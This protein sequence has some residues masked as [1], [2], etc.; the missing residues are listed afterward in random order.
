MHMSRKNGH[1]SWAFLKRFNV[2]QMDRD[3]PWAPIHRMKAKAKGVLKP[4]TRRYKHSKQQWERKLSSLIG[5]SLTIDL[6]HFRPLRLRREED[7][8]DWLIWLLETSTTGVLAK[9]LFGSCM[10][11]NAAALKLPR[12]K[13]ED[14]TNDQSRRV[15]ILL[16]WKQQAVDVEVKI[17]DMHLEKTGETAEKVERKYREYSWHHFILLSDDLLTV[18]NSIGSD[19]A[20]RITIHEI[21]WRD[22]VRALRRCLWQERE[23]MLWR[24]WAW[25]FCRAIENKVMRLA[26]PELFRSDIGK[27]QMTLSWLAIIEQ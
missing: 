26:D 2:R 16:M 17:E 12:T 13:R 1:P 23:S 7:W 6:D 25:L 20:T 15:D 14:W 27:L 24:A 10:N 21:L 22:V 4:T 11:C 5:D 19:R 3:K 8:S 9:A 18:W